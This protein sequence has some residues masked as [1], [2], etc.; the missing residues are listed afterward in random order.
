MHIRHPKGPLTWLTGNFAILAGFVAGKRIVPLAQAA[1]GLLFAERSLVEAQIEQEGIGLSHEWAGGEIQDGHD[2]FAVQVGA[3]GINFFAL[4]QFRYA[5]LEIVVG[6]RQTIGL[7]LVSG[8]DIGPRQDVQSI[9][10]IAG[11]PDI[12][13]DGRVTPGALGVTKEPQVKL[14]KPR[15]VGGGLLIEP[16]RF[17]SLDGQFGADHVVMVERHRAARFEPARLGLANVVQQRSQAK[18][19][20]GRG[21]GVALML[22]F[23]GLR[24]HRQA[25]L[26]N[27]LVVVV[28]IDLEAER[29]YFGKHA[30]GYPRA[31]QKANAL[32][33]AARG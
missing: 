15:D 5:A 9:K 17:E 8:C 33:R 32:K 19:H 26:I 16:Q 6:V 11:I 4:R 1:R 21:G 3:H 29:R 22:Q 14:D 24:Q 28:L 20:I 7:S 27:V 10:L 13:S 30:V 18:R 31:Y 25:V 12:T 23:N 2:L